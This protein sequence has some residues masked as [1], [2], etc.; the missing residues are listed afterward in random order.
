MTTRV[1]PVAVGGARA[2]LA[3]ALATA[4]AWWFTAGSASAVPI[5]SVCTFDKT[6]APVWTLTAN[7]AT[8]VP[9]E[10]PDG[11][12]IDGANLTISASNPPPPDPPASSTYTGAVVTNAAG[13]TSMNIQ[14]LIITGPE[15][16]FPFVIPQD[17]CNAFPGPGLFGIFFNDASG[18]VD[19]VQVLNI[20]QQVLPLP[21]SGGP[22]CGVGHAIRADGVTADRTLTITNTEVSGYQKAGMFASGSMTMNVSGS[23]I[24]PASSVPFSIATNAMNWTNSSTNSSPA[25]G[26]SGTMTGSTIIGSSYGSSGPAD[27]AAAASTAALLFGAS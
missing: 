1:R 3:V 18:S 20:F 17:S 8:T 13:A 23:T 4:G 15:T 7:C 14:N 11:I 25:V 27:P 5:D 10:V 19:N 9:L 21:E 16:G 24:G 6:A 22:A 26:A 2:V 12:T